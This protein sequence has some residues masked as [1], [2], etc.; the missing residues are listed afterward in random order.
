MVNG[1]E[2]I[3]IVERSQNS[4]IPKNNEC[5]KKSVKKLLLVE[6][7][8]IIALDKKNKLTKYGYNVVICNT[9]EK[10]VAVFK[11]DDK[12]DLILMDIDL[13]PGM[14]GTEAA[15]LILRDKDLPV[16]FLSS[17]TEPLIVEKTEKI[18]SYGYVVK[19]SSI[20]VLD[21]SIK[22][23]FKLFEANRITEE[24][25]RHL[26]ITLNSIG[27]A[28]ISTDTDGKVTNINPVAE[29]LTG[30]S[31]ETAYGT[32]LSDVFTI[33]NSVSREPVENPVNKVLSTG[34]TIELA[35][36]TVLISKEGKEYQIADSASPIMHPDGLITGVVL[37][38]RDVTKEYKLQEQIRESEEKYNQ[39]T[40]SVETILWEF[41]IPKDCWTYVSPQAQK[42]LGYAPEEW[43]NLKFWTDHIYEDDRGWAA[44]YC[45]K[46]TAKGESHEFEYRFVKKNGEIVWLRDVVNVK[47]SNGVPEKMYGF[48][49][50]IS[51]HKQA[52]LG[53]Q[54]E[55]DNLKNILEAMRDGVY[56]V[57]QQFGIQF[58]NSIMVKELGNYEGKKCYKYFY[59]RDSICP[60]CKFP[61]IL[62]GKTVHSEWV[63]PKNGDIFDLL[64][65]PL[66]NQ[67][68]T[69]SKL[70]IFR[71]ISNRNKTGDNVKTQLL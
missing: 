8:A 51:E 48:M 67:D 20:T 64:E 55:R 22:M 32:A 66:K 59:S 6:D 25:R 45:E 15:E 35:N 5:I 24:H 18:T 37:V 47:L 7:E 27:D 60:W 11:E 53:L 10:A 68:G 71:N 33:V 57:N 4:E 26:G 46:C 36:H 40:R 17:H 41:D 14:D 52:E 12:I 70:K 56:I 69:I 61:D 65:T 63:S 58:A 2:F 31:Y 38:F 43:I 50:D 49:S 42:I 39:I 29:H 9:G 13:G 19:S 30:W 23:A 34:G 1:E 62:S 54:N 28:F 3:V 16:V 44:S 21:A